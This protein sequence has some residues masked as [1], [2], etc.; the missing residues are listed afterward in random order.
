MAL[1]SNGLFSEIIF[2]DGTEDGTIIPVLPGTV[3]INFCKSDSSFD[4]LTTNTDTWDNTTMGDV[5]WENVEPETSSNVACINRN[6]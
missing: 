6:K 3:W 4:Q 2:S 5:S 1:F